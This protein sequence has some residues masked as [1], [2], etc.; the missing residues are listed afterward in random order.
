VWWK[1]TNATGAIAGMAVGAAVSL[2]FIGSELLGRATGWPVSTPVSNFPSIVAAPLAAIA[3]VGGSLFHSGREDSSAWWLR[4]HG[5][6]LERRQ[7]SLVRLA[8]RGGG[9]T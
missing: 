1:R 7:A 5:T 3:V 6:A 4:V 2:G 8:A 9:V